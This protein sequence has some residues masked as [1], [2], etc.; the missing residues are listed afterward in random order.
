MAC[1]LPS[2]AGDK[3]PAQHAYVGQVDNLPP[4][5]NR[6]I[7]SGPIANR[8][9]GYHPAPQVTEPGDVPSK[10]IVCATNLLTKFVQLIPGHYTRLDHTV[11][12]PLNRSSGSP[13]VAHGCSPEHQLAGIPCNSFPISSAFL[14]T[15]RMMLQIALMIRGVITWPVGKVRTRAATHSVS[16]RCKWAFG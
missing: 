8:P 13:D 1:Q 6:P 14:I 7:A 4:I 2:N 12:L 5:V 16:G 3:A 11:S 15:V 10:A 9:A